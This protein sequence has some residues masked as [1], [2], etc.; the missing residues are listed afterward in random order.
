MSRVAPIRPCPSVSRPYPSV[1]RPCASVCPRAIFCRARSVSLSSRGASS[2]I[3]LLELL[4]VL[5]IV[6]LLATIAYSAYS[7]HILRAKVAAAFTQISQLELACSQY[8]ADTGQFPPS[9]SLV[10]GDTGQ[11]AE[12]CGYM[13]TALITGLSPHGGPVP[14]RW[15][16]PY[17]EVRQS[18]V[19][20]LPAG[21][22]LDPTTTYPPGSIQLLDP[23][24]MPYHYIRSV[25]YAGL[26][27]TPVPQPS[28]FE[29]W[30]NPST[31][32]IVSWGPNFSSQA[33][34][35][36]GLDDDDVTNFRY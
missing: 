31:F 28:P 22:P 6:G 13:L 1:L 7:G 23:W 25:D 16:G 19:G 5:G 3:T 9:G 17:I 32:Q 11:P 30:Y 33:R 18:H 2:A 14:P 8:E 34:P 24:G 21:E 4:V 27:G 20:L 26:G 35:N 29:F 36:M 12:G 10:F 15:K